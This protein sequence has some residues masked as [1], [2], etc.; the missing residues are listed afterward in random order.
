MNSPRVFATG[1]LV[2]GLLFASALPAEAAPVL[3]GST[4]RIELL[5]NGVVADPAPDDVLVD[6][7]RE[8]TWNNNPDITNIGSSGAMIDGE[9]IDVGAT[10]IIFSMFGGADDVPGQPGYKTTGFGPGARYRFS[11]LFTPGLEEIVNVQIFLTGVV[12]V[13]KGL[14]PAEGAAE[15]LFDSHSV[16][17]LI[18]TLGILQSASNLGTIRLELQVR[19]IQSPVVPEPG[20]LALLGAGVATLVQRRRLHR[21]RNRAY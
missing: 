16:T 12:G 5:D 9:F 10:N 21:A 15:V 17:L 6:M 18:D 3:L 20:T 13:D 1:L 4:I 14:L 19:E 8:V 2:G 11:N 7:F